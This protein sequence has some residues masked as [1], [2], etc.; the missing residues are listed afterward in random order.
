M[1]KNLGKGIDCAVMIEMLRLCIVGK[2]DLDM[3]LESLWKRNNDFKT[4][5]RKMNLSWATERDRCELR[6]EC[7]CQRGTLNT[8][9]M[10]FAL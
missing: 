9:C 1:K 8:T 2:N 3:C 4:W 10:P 5:N 6:I 7:Y